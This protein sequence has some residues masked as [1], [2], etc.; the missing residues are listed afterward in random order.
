[1]NSDQVAEI[2]WYDDPHGFFKGDKLAC[3]I[4]SKNSSLASQLNALLRLAM[5]FSVVLLLFRHFTVAVYLPLTVAF[6]TYFLFS[7][8]LIES[9]LRLQQHDKLHEGMTR[10]GQIC[11]IP[12]SENPYMN[13]LPND[14]PNR[15]PACSIVASAKAVEAL[16]KDDLFLDV[17]DVFN[18]RTMLNHV[19]Y[20][21]PNT[22]VP[23]DQEG[24]AKW[25]YDSGATCKKGDRSYCSQSVD[26]SPWNSQMY[27]LQ[28]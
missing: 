24:F 23:N 28:S 15:P 22:S 10:E 19:F 16:A 13:A 12:T 20:T 1:M 25:C 2:I 3:F 14:R 18:K 21:M 27:A 5:Y 9:S 6:L 8:S 17:D 4:P 11:T 26:E 7:N